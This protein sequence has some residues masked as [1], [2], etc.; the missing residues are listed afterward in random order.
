[1]MMKLM[2]MIRSSILCL[3]ILLK[4]TKAYVTDFEWTKNAK[5]VRIIEEIK[6]VPR[7]SQ[8]CRSCTIQSDSQSH[9]NAKST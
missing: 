4:E 5:C 7:P 1:M 6:A 3:V 8:Q 2:L 9:L